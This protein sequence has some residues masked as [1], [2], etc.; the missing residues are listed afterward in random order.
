MLAAHGAKLEAWCL[1]I[2]L[3]ARGAAPTSFPIAGL[4]DFWKRVIT[5]KSNSGGFVLG[6]KRNQWWCSPSFLRPKATI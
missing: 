6:K 2:V 1:S 5:R 3:G 4:K